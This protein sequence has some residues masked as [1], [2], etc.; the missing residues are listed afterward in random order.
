MMHMPISIF[1]TKFRSAYEV[2]TTQ[3][4]AVNYI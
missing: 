4:S 3:F 1:S 2:T